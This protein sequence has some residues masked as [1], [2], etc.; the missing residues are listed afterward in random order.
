MATKDRHISPYS[1]SEKVK[2]MMWACVQAT[3]FRYS[4]HTWNGFRILLLN[5]FGAKIQRSCIVRRTVRIECPWNLTMGEHTCLGDSV[6]AYCL[7]EVTVGNR[8]SVSQ[9]V[10]LC[11]GTHDYTCETMLLLR[12]P[13]IIGDDAWIA[14]DAFVGPGVM[15]GNGAILG[16]RGVAMKDLD[17]M[18][19]YAGNPAKLIKA[20]PPLNSKND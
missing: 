7:G 20:R 19:I 14:A 5:M 18:T 1:F 10:H 12:L 6:I 15:V 13:I 9:G 16:A 4:F 2:R 8:V 3:L 17:A 11:A